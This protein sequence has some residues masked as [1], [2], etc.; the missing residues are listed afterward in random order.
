MC[1]GMEY[2]RVIFRDTQEREEGYNQSEGYTF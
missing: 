1:L 2:R